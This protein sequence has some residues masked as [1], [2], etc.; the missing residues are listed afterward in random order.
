[1]DICGTTEQL[2][3]HSFTLVDNLQRDNAKFTVRYFQID[4]TDEIKVS[5]SGNFTYEF[6]VTSSQRGIAILEILVDNKQISESPLRVQVLSRNCEE[7]FNDSGLI[8][9]IDGNCIC[10]TGKLQY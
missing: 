10:G 3:P 7:E 6:E 8:A 4:R 5:S 9:D 2:S 1:M